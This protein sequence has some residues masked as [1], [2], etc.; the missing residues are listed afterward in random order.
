MTP[1]SQAIHDFLAKYPPE[2]NLEWGGTP[3]RTG[4]Q[5]DPNPKVAWAATLTAA[6]E[7]HQR[8]A[9]TESDRP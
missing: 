4:S 3:P 9:H 6:S 8:P 5:H 1:L 7:R 2:V